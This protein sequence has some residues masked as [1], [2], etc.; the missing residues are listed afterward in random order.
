MKSEL[1][2]ITVI[3]LCH[4]DDERL[5]MA[6]SS[7]QFAK[8]VLLIEAGGQINETALQ[9]QYNCQ[10]ISFPI[11]SQDNFNFSKIRNEAIKYANHDWILFLDSDEVI[12]SPSVKKINKIVSEHKYD[13]VYVR[14]EDYFLGKKINWGEAGNIWLLRMGKKQALKFVRPVH[15]VAKKSRNSIYA[16]ITLIH[17]PHSSISEFFSK[18]SFYT[19]IQARYQVERGEGFS[20]VE[21]A[22]YP[23]GKFLSNFFLKLGFLDGWRGFVYAILMSVHS[24]AVRVHIYELKQIQNK[25]K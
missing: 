9:K 23:I 19:H 4:R 17:F 10:K 12:T 25:F 13:S 1:T 18:I 22:L 5:R 20:M 15:E 8:Q 14:R 2:N 6:I 24:F 7:A 16:D 11:D 21:T 3:I